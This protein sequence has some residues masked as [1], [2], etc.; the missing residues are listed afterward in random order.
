MEKWVFSSSRS[1]SLR[2]NCTVCCA[3]MSSIIGNSAA[4]NVDRLKRLRPALMT[5]FSP[6]TVSDTDSFSGSARKISR[7]LRPGTV[8]SPGCLNRHFR[9]GHQLHF[10]IGRRNEQLSLTNA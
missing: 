10:Q 3:L 9:R 6:S 1:N 7:N 2:G 4:G 5:T 8:M